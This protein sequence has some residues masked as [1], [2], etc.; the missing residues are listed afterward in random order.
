MGAGRQAGRRTSSRKHASLPEAGRSRFNN[1]DADVINLFSNSKIDS[2]H[3]A[4]QPLVSEITSYFE[5]HREHLRFGPHDRMHERRT[6]EVYAPGVC[7]SV[8]H[9]AQLSNNG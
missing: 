2:I 6:I 7:Q 8:C 9:V 4:K 5:R 3:S 1:D